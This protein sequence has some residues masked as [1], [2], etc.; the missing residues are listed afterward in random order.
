M[1]A[2]K[3]TCDVVIIGGGATGVGVLRDAAMRGL[4][5]I[6]VERVDLGQGTTGR[7]HGLLHSGGRYVVSDPHSATECAE[8]NAI[9]TRIHPDAVEATGGLF[10]SV[11]GDDEEFPDRFFKGAEETG[12]PTAEISVKE[13]LRREPRLNPRIARAFEVQDGTVD[14][15][16]MVWGA[17][18]RPKPTEPSV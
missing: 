8:E 11:A 7:Y 10:V 13:A 3:L 4:K 18:D 6:L 2:K 16:R 17:V 15:W 14:G 9:L 1:S 5:A 12:V